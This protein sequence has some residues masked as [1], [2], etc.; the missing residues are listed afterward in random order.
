MSH[1]N[2]F[3]EYPMLKSGRLTLKKIEESDAD[4]LFAIYGNERIFRLRPGKARKNIDAVRNM[5]GHFERD[6]KKRKMIFL[7]I[8]LN[9]GGKKLI[10]VAEM[11][12][13]DKK[14]N[15]ITIGYTLN[16]E[17]RGKGYAS[18]TAGLML[19]FLFNK[20]G[21]NRVQAFVMPENV[22]SGKVL[23]RNNFKKEGTLRECEY[24]T[25]KGV[26]D[27]EVYSILKNEYGNG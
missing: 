26:V 24:W 10:G 9:E 6:F 20:I 18:E 12:G 8:Y 5:V 11:F 3:A 15:S 27:L 25:G 7:G 4:D 13:L 19:G 23:L 22:K 2:L 1:E 21:I 17:Y 16:E 14:V